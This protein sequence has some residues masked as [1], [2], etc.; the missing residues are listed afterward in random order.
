MRDA[1]S[2]ARVGRVWSIYACVDKLA[3][4]SSTGP[5]FVLQQ[6]SALTR[7][8]C[9]RVDNHTL[10]DVSANSCVGWLR[11]QAAW[12]PASVSTRVDVGS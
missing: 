12:G 11:G 6:T 9:L 5:C 7:L 4:T 2:V 1:G 10:W 3:L 8:R